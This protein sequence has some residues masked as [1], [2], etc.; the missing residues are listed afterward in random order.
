MEKFMLD[1][2]NQFLNSKKE[3]AIIHHCVNWAESQFLFV[4][5]K[6]KLYFFRL[7]FRIKPLDDEIL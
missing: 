1:I 6:F 7:T 4:L 3:H 2:V 5:L